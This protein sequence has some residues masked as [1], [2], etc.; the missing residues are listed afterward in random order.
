MSEIIFNGSS[1]THLQERTCTL[2][3]HRRDDY[4]R[5]SQKG[6]E[7]VRCAHGHASV[8]FQARFHKA[9]IFARAARPGD[10]RPVMGVQSREKRAKRAR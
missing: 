10:L 4:E 8:F 3:G 7:N 9:A 6:L 5:R 2:D 1:S